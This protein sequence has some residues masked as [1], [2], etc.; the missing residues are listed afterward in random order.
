MTRSKPP[1]HESTE[2]REASPE[3]GASSRRP[4]R[5]PAGEPRPAGRYADERR[6]GDPARRRR[7]RLLL[8]AFVVLLAL[9]WAFVAE[10]FRIPSES[11]QPTLRPGDQVLLDKLAYRL[12]SPHRDDLVVFHSP[13][14]GEISLK[15]IVGLPGD[16]IGV[17]DGV[18]SVNG[19]REREAY[20][21]YRLTDSV[22][23][24]PVTVPSGHVF[25]M[26]DNRSNSRDSR[27][28]GPVSEKALMGRVL[29]R[30][31]PLSR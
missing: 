17:E 20:V 19:H 16:R 31:W 11:M 28:Y 3:G 7:G 22:Y 18:L 5:P 1:T 15:R 14:G 29:L 4:S 25:V 21:N 30:L 23:F 24:G 6:A 2:L 12:G 27:D 26:G 9:T 10:P 13:E 8:A